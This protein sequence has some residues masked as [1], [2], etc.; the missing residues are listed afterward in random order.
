MPVLEAYL[1]NSATTKPCPGARKRLLEAVDL[2]WGNPSSLHQKGLEAQLLLEE[3]RAFIAKCLSCRESELYFT[4]GGTESNNLAVFGAA[5]AMKR[6]GNKIVVSSVEHPSVSRAFD[7]LESDGFTVV[8][9]PVDRFGVVPVE[10]IE[11]AVDESTVLVSMMA[12]NN[13]LGSVEP[14]EALSRIVKEKH[15][16]ALI[17]VDAVQAFGK[18]PLN[19]KKL[20]VDLMS[21]SAHKIHGTKGAGALFVKASVRLAPHIFGGGQE[22]N[23]R[24]GTE[25]LPAIAAFFGAAEEL[26]IKKSLPAVTALRD[27]FVKKLSALDG[28]VI[29]SGADALPYIVNISLPGRPA[30]AVLNF[31][32]SKGIYVSSGSACAKGRRSPTLTAAGLESERVNSSLRISLSRFTT[33]DELDFCL[34][35]IEEA[36]RAIRKK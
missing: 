24:P 29:N 7:K 11:N 26:D 5:N 4:S 20:G 12:V 23:V 34:E 31:L 1:D 19:V 13:E 6:K 36:L 21:V 8:R 33:E 27:G 28:V 2:L 3:A 15:S 9:L 18:L 14:V 25:P 35:G 22:K 32:S 10:E 17:H 16:P 30:E